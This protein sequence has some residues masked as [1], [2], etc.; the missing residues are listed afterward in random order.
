MR[1]N[2]IFFIVWIKTEKED[3]KQLLPVIEQLS[4]CGRISIN[5][6]PL[7]KTVSAVVS[8]QTKIYLPVQVLLNN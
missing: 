7:Q 8:H 6:K 2:L 5:S 3:L 4:L 1:N